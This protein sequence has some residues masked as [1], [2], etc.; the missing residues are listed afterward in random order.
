MTLYQNKYRIESARCPTWD[1]TSNGLYFVT[2]C[3]KNRRCFFGH[4]VDGEMQLSPMG[5]IVA[6]EWQKTPQIRPNVQLDAWVVMPN[7]FHAIIVINQPPP[8]ETFRRN[9]STEPLPTDPTD[10]T[11]SPPTHQKSRLQSNSLGAIVGQFKSIC[12]KRIWKSGFPDFAWQPRFH[13]HIIRNEEAAS[14]IRHYIRQ[15]PQRWASDR[16]HRQK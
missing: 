12:T 13:D 7:H 15:N 5:A 4:V 14:R 10:P 6:E 3:T 2:I 9:V 11:K 1:Y 16:H 8:V